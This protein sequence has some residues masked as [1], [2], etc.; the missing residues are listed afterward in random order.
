MLPTELKNTAEEWLREHEGAIEFFD[1][2]LPVECIPEDVE[3][4]KE[5]AENHGDEHDGTVGFRI[6]AMETGTGEKGLALI[7]VKGHSWE[8]IRIWVEGIFDSE[9]DVLARIEEM[10]F[11]V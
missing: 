7:L 4:P 11:Q 10:G 6:Q 2:F 5:W 1:K 3:D 9:G 8:G